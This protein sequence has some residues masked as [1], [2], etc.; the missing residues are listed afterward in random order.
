MCLLFIY[1]FERV[2]WTLGQE[3]EIST[4]VTSEVLGIAIIS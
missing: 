4:Y 3:S 1:T 2:L